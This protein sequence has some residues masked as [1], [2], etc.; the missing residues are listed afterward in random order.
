MALYKTY[1]NDVYSELRYRATWLPGTAV[2]V[3]DVGR[4]DQG[5]LKVDSRP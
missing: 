1:A 2:G 4:L 5:I 3:G